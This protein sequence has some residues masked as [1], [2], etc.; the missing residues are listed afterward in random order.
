MTE[1]DKSA[2]PW[3]GLTGHITEDLVRKTMNGLQQSVC[4]VAGPPG[5]VAA[6]RDVLNRVGVNDDDIRSEEFFGY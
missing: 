5:L 1:M 3:Q 4:Y 2:M 6:M